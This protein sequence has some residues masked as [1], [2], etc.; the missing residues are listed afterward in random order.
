M[1]TDKAHRDLNPDPITGAPGS[2]PVGV[3]LGS[4]GG[5]AAGAMAGA[6]F[7]PI[8]LLVGAAT[9]A[10]AGAAVGK[11]IA[12]RIDPTGEVEYWREA[13]RERPYVRSD[14]D[15]E[16]DYAAAYGLGLQAR[17]EEPQ[18]RWEEQETDLAGRWQSQK[19]DSRL[20]WDDARPAARD[21][22]ERADLTYRTYDA[23]D[24]Y[25][26][27]RYQ[28]ADYHSDDLSFD[29]YRPAYRY[30]TLART[31]YAGRPWDE[32]LEN[33]LRDQWNSTEYAGRMVWENARPAIRD[34]YTQYE[35]YYDRQPP[36]DR[37]DVS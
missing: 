31:R 32:S 13:H 7:G 23:S 11:G 14:Y 3:G 12:E 35:S 5:V 21:A 24:L 29:D 30:G 26:S 18:R 8:G 17:E 2:H 19:G 22:W 37:L 15:Y 20:E 25:F 6:L 33:A 28:N 4:V 36:A 27:E 9:G 16:R 34:A 1:T 10:V